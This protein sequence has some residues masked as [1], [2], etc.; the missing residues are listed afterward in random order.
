MK[1]LIALLLLI[2]CGVTVASSEVI[3]SETI[4]IRGSLCNSYLKFEKERK[5][6]VAF[7]GGSITEMTGWRDMVEEQLKERFPHTAFE[8]VRAGIASTGS[9]PGAFR[10]KSDVLKDGQVDLLFVEAAVNDD[11]NHFDYIGQTR[12]MEGEIRQALLSNPEMDI[13]MLHFI[14]D[15]FIDLYKEGRLPDVLYNHER[16]ANHYGVPSINLISEINR[17]MEAGEFTWKEFGGTHPAPLGHRY[18]AAAIRELLDSMWGSVDLGK[19]PVPHPVPEKPLDRYSYYKGDFLDIGKAELSGGWEIVPLWNPDDK[20]GKRNRFV[21]IP[22]LE[23]KTPGAS[24]TLRFEGSAIGIFCVAGPS[25]GII[26]YSIDDAPYKTLDTY[27][28]WSS[29]L[30]IPWA[31]LL[32]DELPEGSHTLLLRMSG[33]KNPASKGHELQIRNFLINN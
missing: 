19:E 10:F 29:G 12:G 25:A 15:P 33:E 18:Y 32:E 27:T 21:N 4:R 24:L 2:V 31:Y 22:M 16:V 5:G 28:E 14:Y 3:T 9:T 7:L 13:I 26:E 20:A 30:Y 23:A 17:R 8:F 6:R 11:T 1:R